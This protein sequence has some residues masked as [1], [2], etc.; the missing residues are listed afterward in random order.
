MSIGIGYN[1]LII[2]DSKLIPNF[3]NFVECGPYDLHNFIGHKL[4][5]NLSVHIARTP[6]CESNEEQNYFVEHLDNILKE[7]KYVSIGIHV[8][9]P[10]SS[11][12]GKYGFSSHY[13]YSE[14]NENRI[15]KF[16]KKLQD[17][18][19]TEVWLENV[20]F[21]S[22]SKSEVFRNHESINRICEKTASGIVA[23]LTHLYVDA[24]N[25]CIDPASLIGAVNWSC[26][27]EIHLAGTVSSSD[28]AQHDGHSQPVPTDV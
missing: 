21:Y 27:K 15:I 2:R 6:M 8:T 25:V 26:V 13:S 12:I 20:N 9:G 18:F 1:P 24:F 3:V 22:S 4:S 19:S 17:A 5:S 23:D 28:G 14:K 11:G 7:Y 16:V 10:R